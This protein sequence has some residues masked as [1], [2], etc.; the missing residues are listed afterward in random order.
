MITEN[1][2]PVITFDELM[3]V[4]F[5]KTEDGEIITANPEHIPLLKEFFDVW[6]DPVKLRAF[7]ERLGGVWIEAE[8]TPGMFPVR[9]FNAD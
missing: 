8:P 5:E 7:K 2:P 6:R 9:D 4:E 3:K 1:N